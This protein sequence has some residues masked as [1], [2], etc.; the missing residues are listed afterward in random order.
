[1][2]RIR[3]AMAQDVDFPKLT[4]TVECDEPMLEVSRAAGESASG[5]AAR[6]KRLCLRLCSGTEKYDAKFLLT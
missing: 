1:M 5:D 6:V 4:G 2:N 3:F